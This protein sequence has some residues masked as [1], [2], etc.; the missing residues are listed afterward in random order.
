MTN[1]SIFDVLAALILSGEASD[2]QKIAFKEIL[3]SSK[4][5]QLAFEKLK[6]IWEAE[7]WK[8]GKTSQR[9]QDYL[10]LKYKAELDNQRKTRR[11]YFYKVA[12]V[13]ILAFGLTFYFL[14]T[15]SEIDQPQIYAAKEMV[16]ETNPGERLKTQLP[17]GTIVH[18]NAGSRLLFPDPFSDS[19]RLVYLIGEGYFD[20]APDKSRPFTVR[21]K[22][23]DI[24]AL[25]TAFGV[26]A[27]TQNSNDFVSLVSGKLL[28][29][30]IKNQEMNVEPGETVTLSRL[31][32]SFSKSEI[33]YLSQIAWKDGILHFNNNSFEEIKQ[34][35]E[36][37]YGV[38]F[39]FDGQMKT[40]Q[41]VYTG[42]FKNESLDNILQ[43]LSFSMDF[44]YEINGKKIMMKKN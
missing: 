23:M 6:C 25:G 12:A 26:N 3:E 4:E 28:I 7:L 38:R 40:I 19:L 5:K 21:V 9:Q 33:D 17:D 11:S 15:Q 37:S 27:Y 8:R 20:V 18:L 10:W 44:K 36:L 43:I 14:N 29:R 22:S 1:K 2:K 32:Y 35:L 31:N 34:I 42:T 41:D 39:T 16:K 13:I 30:N 24:T